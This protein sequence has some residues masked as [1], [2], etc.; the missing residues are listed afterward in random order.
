MGKSEQQVQMAALS[1]ALS[2]LANTADP[3]EVERLAVQAREVLPATD[4]LRWSIEKFH[5]RFAEVRRDPTELRFA[6]ALLMHAV[7]L[8]TRPAQVDAHRSDIHG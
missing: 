7:E 4:P 6:A 2:A 5:A 1:V 8:A 3:I